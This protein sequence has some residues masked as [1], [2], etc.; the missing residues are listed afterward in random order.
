MAFWCTDRL[1][2]VIARSSTLKVAAYNMLN[3]F[4]TIDTT[5]SSSSGPCGANQ[6]QDCRGAD[7]VNEFNRQR[8]KLIQALLG[9]GADVYG[10]AEMENTP[11]VDP[12]ADLVNGLNAI[13]GAG[14]M[15]GTHET[16][17]AR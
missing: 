7:S 17:T 13:A 9:I 6:A 3:Y 11:N 15:R 4:L 5:S 16:A 14:T 8:S 2:S 12:L 10:L 1:P